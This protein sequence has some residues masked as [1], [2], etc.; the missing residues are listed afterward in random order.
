[1]TE[2]AILIAALEVAPPEDVD[3][4]LRAA[5]ADPVAAPL[6][7]LLY[8]PFRQWRRDSSA[9]LSPFNPVK[10]DEALAREWSFFADWIEAV[11]L[12]DVTD[13]ALSEWRAS[14]AWPLYWR[15]L[16]K[17]LNCDTVSRDAVSTAIGAVPQ[18]FLGSV[19]EPNDEPLQFP[20]A[21]EP[22]VPGTRCI[23]LLSRP[24]SSDRCAWFLGQ[25]GLPF[26]VPVPEG[27]RRAL[28]QPTYKK[29]PKE[30]ADGAVI[31]GVIN[32]AGYTVFDI[33]PLTQ[34]R[35]QHRT[36][37]YDIRA[38]ALA[39]VEFGDGVHNVPAQIVK[40]EDAL[41]RAVRVVQRRGFGQAVIKQPLAP[42]PYFAEQYQTQAWT[43][44]RCICN[45]AGDTNA[46]LPNCLRFVPTF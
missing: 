36:D 11:S 26:P 13:D 5:A 21:V 29:L 25:H 34:F 20:C 42:Y 30:F 22:Y 45:D 17:R 9:D 35:E 27:I 18:F 44:P 31:D 38:V 10:A 32:M 40:D 37:P 41:L 46:H 24:K 23:T 43:R 4:L 7:R 28:T 1:M 2:A 33:V 19:I 6:L 39:T 3:G 8:D 16:A 15:V 12:T 14:D